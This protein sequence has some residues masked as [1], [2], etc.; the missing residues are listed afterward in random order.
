[1]MDEI[2]PHVRQ[3]LSVGK[4]RILSSITRKRA[5]SGKSGA[6]AREMDFLGRTLDYSEWSTS[7][8]I[9]VTNAIDAARTVMQC[10]SLV[11]NISR[12]NSL[13]FS[14]RQDRRTNLPVVRC[15]RS[16]YAFL[17]SA[18][19]ENTA[20]LETHSPYCALNP[21]VQLFLRVRTQFLQNTSSL[22]MKSDN[23]KMLV[24][25]L[26]GAIEQLRSEARSEKFRKD[27]GKR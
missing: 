14:I 2:H 15:H 18:I 26:N 12:S 1:M 20:E 10:A 19:D 27:L 4:H 21:Y 9:K 25:Q 7:G 13:L 8:T 23:T 5:K 24:D 6:S 17:L 22:S 16:G 11:R 3:L